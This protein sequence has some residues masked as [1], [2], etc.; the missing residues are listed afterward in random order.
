M[1]VKPNPS[2]RSGVLAALLALLGSPAWANFIVYQDYMAFQAIRIDGV[3]YP[4]ATTSDLTCAFIAITGQSDT[5]TVAPFS[6]PG[7]SGFKNSLTAAHIDVSFNDGRTPYSADIDLGVGGLYVSVDQTNS[8]AGFS[9]SYG[10]TYPLATFGGAAF[11]T[12]DLASDFSASGFGPFCPAFDIPPC[13]DDGA[14]K[15]VDGTEFVITR[16]LL[17]YSSFS[18]TVAANPI[19]EPGSAG[20]LAL[21][22][23]ALAAMRSARPRIR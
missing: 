19:P 17:A 9:S 1:R 22:L 10:P 23:A 2:L 6:V 15:A 14:L 16:G 3:V 20:L 21:S 8:G 4:C 5:S 11:A 13:T 18:S 12:Y 7:A